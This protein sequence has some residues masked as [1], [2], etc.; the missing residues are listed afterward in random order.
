MMMTRRQMIAALSAVPS[1]ATHDPLF[2]AL[3][4]ALSS[5]GER[6]TSAVSYPGVSYRDYFRCL[7]N[8]LE[9]LAARAYETRNQQIAALT[10]PAAVRRRQQ[11]SRETFWKL[12]GGEPERTQ[13]NLRTVGGFEREHY[14]V[15]KLLYESQPNLYVSANL[16]IPKSYKP[17]FPGI[18]FQ[19]GHTMNGKAG[20]TYQRCC[21][22]LAQ[23]GYLVLG[24][25]PMGQ[26]ERIYYP[27]ASGIKSRIAHHDEEHSHAGRQMLLV[28]DSATRMQTW[29]AVRSLDVL[30][31]HPLV[32]PK[33]I[34]AT[35]QSGGATAS[36]FLA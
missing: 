1:L 11:W 7:P 33:R 36:M 3:S 31:S 20:D 15:E 13:L 25:D 19:M 2:A 8:V 9:E 21:Q 22:G 5:P 34:G 6:V 17:P 35:G 28:G 32:D 26:G 29:D 4:A 10:A 12:V 23:L 27:D 16:Y 14:R 18:L 24:F 30:A